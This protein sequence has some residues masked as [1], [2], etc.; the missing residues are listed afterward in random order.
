AFLGQ[1]LVLYGHHDLLRGG[2][3]DLAA[4]AAQIDALGDVRWGSLGQI[5]R[6]LAGNRQPADAA[7][8]ANGVAPSSGTVSAQGAMSAEELAAVPSPP[9]RLRPIV[10]R[11]AAESEVRLRAM[12]A[13]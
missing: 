6:G 12:L 1:P 9:R 3:S 2:P 5:A 11:V 7:V 13:R 4:A 8:H 10:R